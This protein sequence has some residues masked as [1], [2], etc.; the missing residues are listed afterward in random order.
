MSQP[1]ICMVGNSLSSGG[2]DRIH[3]VLSGYFAAQGIEV[4][5]VIFIDHVTYEFGG[6]LL[7]L[8]KMKRGKGIFDLLKRFRLLQD[9]FS[10]EQFDYIIDFRNRFKPWQELF[11]TRILYRT[12]YVITIHSYRTD[13]YIPGG[14]FISKTIFND[15][16]GLVAVSKEIEAKVKRDYGYEKVSTI[17]NPLET[18]K[19]GMLSIEE[20]PYDFSFVLGVGRMVEDN[21][22]Q[23]DKMILAYSKSV[24]PSQQTR[25]VLLGE[26][27]QQQALKKLAAELGI[28]EYVV[29]P[30]FIQNP[31]AFMSK[32]RF[33][34][35]CSKNEGLPNTITESLAC[36][37]PVVAFDCKSGPS[38]LIEDR[39]NGL[40]VADQ[41]FEKF[42]EAMNEMAE[43][44]NL[45]RDC[46]QHAKA[47]V[48]RFSIDEIGAAWL[49]YLKI[50]HT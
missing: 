10:R 45:Y 43:N 50:K 42:T 39:L 24:L 28:A 14:R 48:A 5:N 3:A 40:L 21:N 2:A 13:W 44:T 20:I 33:T 1:K 37:T 26:G 15:A 47:S 34:L 23:F 4:H 8:G 22:K 46:K 35:L 7:N 19:I 25:L 31:Y 41:D 36:G 30:G 11:F 12:P 32:A 17:Y 29:F 38:E 49:Q 18:E 27:P 6:T 9:Y 16:Y